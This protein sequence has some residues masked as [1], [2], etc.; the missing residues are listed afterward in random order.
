MSGVVEV[1]LVA[2]MGK[3]VMPPEPYFGAYDYRLLGS[4]LL[5][6]LA[7]DSGTIYGRYVENR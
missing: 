2:W 3:E 6:G 7:I 5:R 1:V 4:L